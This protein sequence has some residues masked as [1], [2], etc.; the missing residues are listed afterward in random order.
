[1][2]VHGGRFKLS[3][4]YPQQQNTCRTGVIRWFVTDGI[5]LKKINPL[6]SRTQGVN[7]IEVEGNMCYFII[8]V[9]LKRK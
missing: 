7:R 3:T 6:S 9:F 4:G 8:F 5:E 1:M 2:A